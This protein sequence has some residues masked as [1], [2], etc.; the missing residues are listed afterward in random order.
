MVKVVNIRNLDPEAYNIYV[1]RRKAL[2]LSKYE[3]IP[4]LKD[5]SV[6][7]NP[8]RSKDDLVSTLERYREYFYE[9]LDRF[10]PILSEVIEEARKRT[11][12]LVCWCKP[13]ACHGDIIAEYM[14]SLIS[15][16]EPD[17]TTE[18]IFED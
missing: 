2:L 18:N 14:N 8:F 7:G 4:G 6:F 10:E 13:K 3:D 16:T 11:V 1:G 12:C 15:G 9:N 17:I 5:G